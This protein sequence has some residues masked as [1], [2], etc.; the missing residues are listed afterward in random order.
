MIISIDPAD[1]RPI[2]VQITDEVRRGIVLGALGPDDPLP[3]VRQ[4]AAELRVNPNTVQ[5]AYRELEREKIVYVRR[6]QGT[7]IAA[8]A[9][10]PPDAERRHL[11]EAL[12][13]RILQEAYRQGLEPAELIDTIR[14]LSEGPAET[15]KE[16]QRD[17]NDPDIR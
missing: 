3:S 17:D 10:S 9:A 13:R 14:N 2:Y 1:P 4:L 11:T 15:G 12:A 6:G 5:Q 16:R 7:F 8:D